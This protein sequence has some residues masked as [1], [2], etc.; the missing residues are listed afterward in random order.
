MTPEAQRIAIAEFRGFKRI[1]MIEDCNKLMGDL[2][3]CR[4]WIEIPDYLYDL[5]AMHGIE[6]LLT[7]EQRDRLIEAMGAYSNWSLFHAS[8]SQRAEALLRTIGKWQDP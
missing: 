3:P 1:G 7:S 5:N 8:N 6:M 2:P 4:G